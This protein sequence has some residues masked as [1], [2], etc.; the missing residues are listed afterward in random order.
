MDFIEPNAK[1]LDPRDY[2]NDEK[3]EMIEEWE[4][5]HGPDHGLWMDTHCESQDQWVDSVC[6]CPG[7]G[8]DLWERPNLWQLSHVCV[9][10]TLFCFS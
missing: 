10:G 9:L 7:G 1:L 6:L 8:D 4:Q 2:T 3:V 5:E